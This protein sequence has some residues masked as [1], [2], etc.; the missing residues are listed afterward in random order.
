MKSLYESIL[1]DEDV[2]VGG[3]KKDANNPYLIIK[4]SLLNAKSVSDLPND[5]MSFI[6]NTLFLDLN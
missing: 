1:D 6:K 4:K 5:F 3:L 2:L